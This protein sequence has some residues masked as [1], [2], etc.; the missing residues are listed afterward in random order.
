MNHIINLKKLGLVLAAS[1]FF[2]APAYADSKKDIETIA[3][4]VGFINGGPSG[5]ITMDV[6]FDP[7]NSD[8]VAH[9]D[10][11]IALTSGGIGKKVKLTGNKVSSAGAASS[12]VIFVTRGAN[13]IYGAALDKAAAN[14]G[15][16]VSTDEA[17]LGG[18][19]VLVVKTEPSVDILVSSAAA[20]KTGTEFA[21]AFSMMITKK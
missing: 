16:T 10:E 3:K 18:G 14:G 15:L 17:C 20:G 4:A 11:I 7:S 5:A 13:S 2:S 6:L 19:C 12:K 8:S 21:S 1:A 9:A